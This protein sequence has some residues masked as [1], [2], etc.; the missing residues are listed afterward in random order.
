LDVRWCL[1]FVI[2]GKELPV[3]RNRIHRFAFTLIELLVVIAIIAILIGL[4]IP[5][6]QKVREAAA[7]IQSVNNCKQMCLAVN[8]VASNTSTG[9]IP[10][11][12][13]PFPVGSA[14]QSFFTALLPYIEQQNLYTTW[15]AAPGTALTNP[16]KTYIAPAD[17]NNPG[18]S[19]LISY[20]SNGVLLNS[21]QLVAA[22]PPRLPSSFFGRTSSTIV[23]MERTG[24][25]WGTW[26][27]IPTSATSSTPTNAYDF[28][29]E[30][31]ATGG[32]TAVTAIPSGTSTTIPEFGSPA[33]WAALAG[34]YAQ[35]TGLTAAGCIVGMGDG[36]ARVVTNGNASAAWGWAINPQN[37]NPQPSGW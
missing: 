24:K 25:N 11:A 10:P 26:Q 31:T 29:L 35:A 8:N 30:G 14:P 16:V 4:L 33:N 3:Y 18:T 1:V 34:P 27:M 9:D 15:Q 5:A 37:P 36:S 12:Y 20:A 21:N 23:V 6:V 17:P 28:L 22:A 32:S 13:G 19:A 7:R 2:L